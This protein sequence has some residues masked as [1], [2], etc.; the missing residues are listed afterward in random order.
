MVPSQ[1]NNLGVYESRVDMNYFD[2]FL[3]I[4]PTRTVYICVVEFTRAC[5][6]NSELMPSAPHGWP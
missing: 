5:G 3:F 6:Q 4:A 2:L 1:L